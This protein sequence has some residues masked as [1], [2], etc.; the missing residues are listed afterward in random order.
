MTD[1]LECNAS[2]SPVPVSSTTS[3]TVMPCDVPA[4]PN[5]TNG[6]GGLAGFELYADPTS[7]G[8]DF[9]SPGP[10]TAADDL[11]MNKLNND[12]PMRLYIDGSAV[13][14]TGSNFA[15]STEIEN[16]TTGPQGQPLEVHV[17]DP[18][19]SDPI[20]PATAEMTTGLVA[21]DGIVGVLPAYPGA[22][23]GSTIVMYTEKVLDYFDVGYLPAGTFGNLSSMTFTDFPNTLSAP[24]TPVNGLYTVTIGDFTAQEPVTVTC[25]GYTTRRRLGPDR[26][27]EQRPSRRR[28]HEQVLRRSARLGRGAPL[29]PPT[30]RRGQIRKQVW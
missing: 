8:G 22:P 20:V 21:P 13:Y 5:T 25:T 7:S 27:Y 19:I 6:D 24:L 12:L 23:S 4:G 30:D 9:V 15:L 29:D 2:S 11:V 17:G 14:C 28:H 3:S 10:F 26:V 1:S 18:V 16:C